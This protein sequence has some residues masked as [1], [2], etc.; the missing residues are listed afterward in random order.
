M[1][2]LDARAARTLGVSACLLGAHAGYALEHLEIGVTL[3]QNSHGRHLAIL[4]Q[5]SLSS[6][7]GARAVFVTFE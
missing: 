4:P 7:S 1:Q 2:L 6:A 3:K 5:G